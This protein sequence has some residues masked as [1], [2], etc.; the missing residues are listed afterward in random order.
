MTAHEQE[1]DCGHL[2]ERSNTPLVPQGVADT[3]GNGLRTHQLGGEEEVAVDEEDG[4]NR[5]ERVGAEQR[6]GRADGFLENAFPLGLGC[7]NSGLSDGVVA[8]LGGEE[9]DMEL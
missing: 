5:L 8:L 1:R 2:D 3:C 6:V 7:Q 4:V 9:E